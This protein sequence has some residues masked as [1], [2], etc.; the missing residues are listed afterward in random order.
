MKKGFTLIEL[1]IVITII[2]ILAVAFL[3]SL[4][5]APSKARDTQRVSDVTKI[6]GVLTT[7]TISGPLAAGGCVGPEASNLS[8]TIKKEDFGGKFPNDPS[9]KSGTTRISTCEGYIVLTDSG[10]DYSFGV[11]TKVENT[12]SGNMVCP[13]SITGFAKDFS[14]DAI[15]IPGGATT[16]CFGVLVQ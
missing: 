12:S 5:G 9:Y 11:F 1:L 2:G 16:T 13:A 4:L 14:T 8:G 7:S 10:G 3:P 6:A 15:I